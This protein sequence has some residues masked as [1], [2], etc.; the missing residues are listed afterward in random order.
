MSGLLSDEKEPATRSSGRKAEP[1]EAKYKVLEVGA[2]H[3]LVG[4][5]KE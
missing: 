2:A 5:L 3:M 1:A 4:S